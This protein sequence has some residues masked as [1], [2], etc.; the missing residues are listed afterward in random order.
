MVKYNRFWVL[1][2]A[3]LLLPALAF[4][5]GSWDQINQQLSKP[6]GW[7]QLVQDSPFALGEDTA[8]PDGKG[9]T[10]LEKG[11]GTYPSID[12]STVAVPMAM[13][14][15]RQHLGLSEVDL[16]GFVAFSTTHSAY[17]NLIGRKPNGSATLV[18]EGAV[19]DSARPVDLIIATYPS[20]E[21]LA[22]AE[23]AGVELVIEPV[24]YDAFVFITH[25]D[26]PV[27]S[28]TVQQIRDIYTGNITQWD[29]VGGGEVRIKPYQRPKNSG[30]Q[31]AMELLVMD[32]IPMMAY[33]TNYYFLNEMSELVSHVGGYDNNSTNGLGY[34][35]QYYINELYK[36]ESIKVL[37]VDGVLPTEENLRNGSYPFTT[38]YY[39]VIR[40]EDKEGLPGQFLDWMLTDEGQACILQAGYIP[41]KETMVV[42]SRGLRYELDKDGVTAWIYGVAEGARTATV[43]PF[44]FGRPTRILEDSWAGAET[45]IFEEGIKSLDD[46]H[47]LFRSKY[48]RCVEVPGGVEWVDS[49]GYSLSQWLR[50]ASR[51][52]TIRL[53]AAATVEDV[54]AIAS[55]VTWNYWMSQYEL[56]HLEMGYSHDPEE[57]ALG[58]R[59]LAR[60][61]I[62][63][64]NPDLYDIDGI[65][66]DR[67][68]DTLL[69][70]PPGR[71]GSYVVPEGTARI[72]NSAFYQCDMLEAV[73]LPRSVTEIG[74]EAFRLCAGLRSVQLPPT[75]QSIGARAFDNC[76][77]LSQLV[78]PA[79]VTVG[80]EAFR[81][82]IGLD[83]ICFMGESGPVDATALSRVPPNLIVYAADG[84]DAKRAAALNRLLWAELGG[85]PQ[86]LQSEYVLYEQPA[87]VRFPTALHAAPDYGSD[88]MVQLKTGTTVS[89]LDFVANA[90]EED[91][92]ARCFLPDAGEGWEGYI[93]QQYLHLQREEEELSRVLGVE[94]YFTG[95]RLYE[96]PSLEAPSFPPRIGREPFEVMQRFGTWY[97]LKST[98]GETL[99][100]PVHMAQAQF[101]PLNDERLYVVS[102]PS[103]EMRVYVYEKAN[104]G[105]ILAA[106][107]N[108]TQVERVG[109]A[110]QVAGRYYAKIRAG[111]VEGY[112]ENDSL[113]MMWDISFHYAW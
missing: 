86:R 71:T 18:T 77:S 95:A 63:P 58:N 60:I 6:E 40:A 1:L 57:S 20:D 26:N 7:A 8:L 111:D 27:E 44:F 64:A 16:P 96:A 21:E 13:E 4:A 106:L 36:D 81:Y 102:S 37:A 99:Y 69:F 41:E 82:C 42:T 51:L 92:W 100:I 39:G 17:K 54:D 87:I 55:K 88:P 24:C 79:G 53:S 110:E 94:V 29:Q 113:Q 48:L 91:G 49:E 12:G 34:T 75:L 85:E 76:I 25:K 62:D 30:S 15:A 89:V 93:P 33:G 104:E 108:G 107:F 28:L 97:V 67:G 9:G 43:P 50:D 98:E 59:T 70:C 32:G 68:T 109:D 3:V 31:T 22:M 10:F 38:H 72:G 35:Y 2:L 45:L 112:V 90:P 84:S 80:Q 52:E 46:Y 19:M 74:A 101:L 61:E 105:A 47:A 14:F 78:I 66:F 23:A 56:L 103:E 5:A 11:F 83:A 65:V 73:T